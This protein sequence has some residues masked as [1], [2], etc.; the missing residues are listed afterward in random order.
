MRVPEGFTEGEVLAA[1]ENAVKV[2]APSFTFGIYDLEDV[3][4]EARME[5]CRVLERYDPRRDASGRPT[6]PLENF[7]Y[8]CIRNRLIR[9]KRDKLRRTDPPCLLCHHGQGGRS[10]HP[11]GQF[12]KGYLEWRKRNDSK[13]GLM[14]PMSLNSRRRGPE[15]DWDAAGAVVDD[16]ARPVED[17]AEASEL[18]RRIDE[19]MPVELRGAYLKMLAGKPVAKS[20]RLQV[21]E[22]VRDA[23]AGG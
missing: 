15:E 17:T 22:V 3:Q 20:R 6:R 2:L 10:Q 12:C 13:S 1:I 19:L 16:A 11:D 4:Q 21:E 7:V 23:L 14:R 5:G 8:T 18:R 9:L